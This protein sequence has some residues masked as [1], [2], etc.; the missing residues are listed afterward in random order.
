MSE[1]LRQVVSS[2][3][4]FPANPDKDK[5]VQSLMAA[6]PQSVTSAWNIRPR[7]A[8]SKLLLACGNYTQ[9]MEL[10]PADN[11]DVPAEG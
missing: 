1:V 2:L 6:G 4:Q 8:D 3:G 5:Q 7:E 11:V 10:Y 9:P